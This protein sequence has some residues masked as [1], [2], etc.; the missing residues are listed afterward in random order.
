MPTAMS[1]FD[2]GKEGLQDILDEIDDAKIQLPDFQRDWRW[3]DEHIRSLLA[4]VSL[5]YPIGAI[6]LMGTGAGDGQFAPRLIDGVTVEMSGPPQRL[7]LDGQQRLTA[8]YQVLKSGRIVSTR[9]TKNRR[10]QRW[11]YLDIAK[12]LDP[13]ADREEAMI[14]LPDD[15]RVRNFRGEVVEDYSDA[16]KECSAGLLPLSIFFDIAKLFQWLDNYTNARDPALA[17]QRKKMRDKLISDV[18]ARFQQYQI[19]VIELKRETPKEAVCQVFEKV[20]TGGV[21]LTVFELVTATFAADNFRLRDDWTQRER[22]IKRWP[23]LANVSSS[24]FL[25]AATLLST[26]E[27]HTSN[28][29]AAVS[30][31]RRDILRMTLSDYRSVADRLTNGF[32]NTARF[33]IR[34]KIFRSRDVPYQTQV[35]P[36][37]AIITG[38]DNLAE[39]DG[40]KQNIARWFWCGVLGELYG[41]AVETRFAKD[42]PELI[43]WVRGGEQPTTIKDFN[44]APQRLVSLRTR[45]SAAYKGLHAL[46]MREGGQDFR[47][48]DPIELQT[49]FDDTVDIHHIFP[50][51]ICNNLGIKPSTYNSIINKTPLSTRTN[52]TV[53]GNLPSTYLGRLQ[54]ICN[55]SEARMDEILKSHLIDPATLRSDNFQAFYDLRH[56]K[57][58]ELIERATGKGIARAGAGASEEPSE[59]EEEQEEEAPLSEEDI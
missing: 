49:Y 23:P 15:R 20:N 47:T 27:R 3:D 7:I 2:S 30:C 9:D 19:P 46:L 10:I 56:T 35:I 22:Q 53:G 26:W 13:N 43:D 42:L 41:A 34:Q 36:L 16:D 11:Y 38:L 8:L 33:L 39:Q 37:A 55:I 14:S 44:F 1:T 4:S 21:S 24:D 18:I 45:N 25:T 28:E 17:D 57:M 31:K 50:R 29:P 59:V 51:Q 6:L 54:R 48:G 52:R 58:L 12:A 5:S 40:V 32:D